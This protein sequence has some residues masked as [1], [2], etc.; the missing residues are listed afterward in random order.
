[1]GKNL[2][3]AIDV[4]ERRQGRLRAVGYLRVSTEEQAKGF[5]IGYT[6]RSVKGYS[7]RKRWDYLE[8]FADEGKSGTL[9]WQE[10][11]DAKRLMELA[12]QTPR[13]FDVVVVQETRAI[14]REDRPFYRWY[15]ELEDLGI[16]VAVVDEDI[17]TTTDEGRSRMRD[18]ANEAFKELVRIRKRTQ[19][20]L[21][22]KVETTRKKGGWVGGQPP[23]GL[24]IKDQG[25]KGKS[26]VRLDDKEVM[27]LDLAAIFIVDEGKSADEA[28][29]QLNARGFRTRT[30]SR[31]TGG[32]LKAKFFN[33]AMLGYIV[34]RNTDPAVSR[35]RGK[36]RT[37]TNADGTPAYGKSIRIKVPAP[38][39]KERVM[40]VRQALT[41]RARPKGGDQQSYPLSRRIIGACGAHYVG[42]YLKE[43]GKR[44]YRC[45]GKIGCGD[46]IILAQ[47]AEDAIWASLVHYLSDR[48]KLRELA[49]MWI[50]RG[51][52][53]REA[54]EARLKELDREIKSLTDS[55]ATKLLAFAES[56]TEMDPAVIAAAMAGVNG[57]IEEK[58]RDRQLVKEMLDQADAAAAYAADIMALVDL[59]ATNLA[60]VAPE[61]RGHVIDLMGITA[62]VAS[63]VPVR[64][65]G[66]S[67]AIEGWFAA[68]GCGVRE[69]TDELWEQVA[70]HVPP[71]RVTKASL[72]PRQVVEATLFKIRTG[73]GWESMP[74]HFPGGTS[75]RARVH[76][77]MASGAWEAMMKPLL[78][79]ELE[80]PSR[81]LLP[82][83]KI[84]GVL[85]PKLE[86]LIKEGKVTD[87]DLA[88]H[89]SRG[90]FSYVMIHD[91]G[92]VAA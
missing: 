69:L 78:D 85:D 77:W 43:E 65:G 84:R 63:P 45:T 91:S 32:N 36:R 28:A 54:H 27:V 19:D 73:T 26:R 10:R 50:G 89:S 42:Q 2:T 29:E 16:F 76:K 33:T 17:D 61:R 90:V 34:F 11:P 14:G 86:L 51:P 55:A 53:H 83:L 47:E 49:E 62:T 13:P 56:N 37:K 21:Q 68:Q 6:G 92:L 57:K 70:E 46:S 40:A 79:P 67:C 41:D 81:R 20:G 4:L 35:R 12:H 58:K 39:P 75:V 30:G 18:K 66:R 31:W 8:T 74:G 23:Y 44:A 48:D 38:L 88:P 72:D 25:K 87:L 22:E 82:D 59:A 24:R 80:P 5:G 9:P 15:W 64:Q 1:M 60:T 71:Y 52:D 3:A 7:K